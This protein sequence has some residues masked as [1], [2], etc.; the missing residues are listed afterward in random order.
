MNS[1]LK[2]IKHIGLF[3]KKRR[4]RNEDVNVHDANVSRFTI[5]YNANVHGIGKIFGMK[6]L[7]LPRKGDVFIYVNICHRLD[8]HFVI[9]AVD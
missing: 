2:P 7:S 3:L 5:E 8:P 9:K 6:K 4:E 1:R